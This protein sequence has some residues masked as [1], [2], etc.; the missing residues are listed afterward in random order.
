MRPRPPQTPSSLTPHSTA[1]QLLRHFSKPS[2]FLRLLALSQTLLLPLSLSPYWIPFLSH[3]MNHQHHLLVM[4]HLVLFV[5]AFNTVKKQGAGMAEIVR[6]ALP[7][8]MAGAVEI[9]RR[10]ERDAERRLRKL[11]GMKYPAKGP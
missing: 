9:Q 11:Q 6:W 2:S 7:E 5:L 3:F 1:S 10:S 8:I 4:A